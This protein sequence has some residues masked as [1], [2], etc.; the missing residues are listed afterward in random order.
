MNY[1]IGTTWKVLI[2]S[3]GLLV[4]INSSRGD[5]R[6]LWF[7]LS[8]VAALSQSGNDA[9]SK[10]FFSDLTPYEMGLIRLLFALP[11]LLAGLRVIAWPPLDRTFWWCM[12][13]GLPLELIA[14]L[15]YMRAI[16]VS[17]LSLTLPFLAFTPA[18][19]ILT[20]S[21]ILNE[22]L[23][24]WGIL[25]IMLI[26]IGS[27]VLNL[28]DA[29][30]AWNAPFKAVFKEQGSWLM[31]LTA[32]IY[33]LTATIGKL[34]IQHSS[35]EFFGISYFV[36]FAFLLMVLFPFM[37]GA[38]VSHLIRRPLIGLFAGL[39]LVTMI[40]S[41]TYA[42]SLVQAAYMLSVKR[43]SIL[44]GVLFGAIIFKEEKVSERF[45]GAAIMMVGVLII[46]FWG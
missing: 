17:P 15:C 20:G 8:L 16:K 39:S 25:G 36:F 46:G 37:P 33:S 26:G 30:Q 5:C 38:R 2:S 22:T 40:F 10:R 11:F 19:V 27:Y 14:F 6:M 41:H 13:V 44:F 3:Q 21:V 24:K 35:P 28:S 9:I 34:A 42:I 29:K 43:S 4:H 1:F 31:L 18:F 32:M 7:F 23:S 45:L 12:G